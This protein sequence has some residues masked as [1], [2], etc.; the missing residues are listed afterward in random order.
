MTDATTAA[1]WRAALLAAVLVAGGGGYWLGQRGTDEMASEAAGSDG[2]KVLYY[3]DPMF[4]NQKFD[5]PGKSPFMDMQLVAK[6]ADEGGAAPGVAVDPSARQ[7]LGIR[8]VAAEMGSLAATLDVTGTV[9]FNQRDVAI[10][11][12]RSGGFV[13]RV[14]RLAPGDVIR[15]GAPIADVQSPEWG[16][17]QTEYLSVKRLGRPDLTAA[18]RQRLR[19]MG[20]P[21]AVIAQVDRSGRTSGTVTVR[22][23]I[24]GVVQTL[25][26]RAGVTLAEGQ[27]LAEISG[28]GTV[29]L[30]AALP[31]AQAGTVQVGQRAIA[32]LTAFPGESFG[33]RVVAILPTA[34]ADSRT[35]TVRV[36]L[37]NRGARLRPGMFASVSLGGDAKPALL[38]P[39]EAVIRTGTR[40]IVMLEMGDGRYHPA[41]VEAGRE[42]GGKTEILRG[43]AAGEKVVASGQFLLDS[44]A[45][46]TGIAVR[47]LEDAK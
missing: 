46:L 20:M 14:Y 23:P 7:S 21:E 17:A 29:W 24:G 15:A 38:V 11:Q 40:T 8:A 27:T 25:G 33:G 28:L 42:G 45:S 35:L 39:S 13:E 30:N 6:Y 9:D 41:E 43:L 22:A 34:A 18:A 3:Y 31:E 2:G 44:E 4:P 16:G 47:P 12:A 5:K 19:L 37:A 36:E 26:A 1:R 10:V 32:K